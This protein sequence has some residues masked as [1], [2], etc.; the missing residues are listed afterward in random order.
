MAMNFPSSPID[1][2]Q[3]GGYVYDTAKGVWSHFDYLSGVSLLGTIYGWPLEDV[4]SWALEAN[5]QAVSRTTYSGLFALYGTTFGVGDG[6]TTFN[7]PNYKGRTLVGQDTAQTEF[8]VLG[9][10]G[11]AK[12]HTL[13]AQELPDHAHNSPGAGSA[14]SSGTSDIKARGIAP[15]DTSFR[16]GSSVYSTGTYGS[17]AITGDRSHNN[18]QPYTVVKWIICATTS[19]GDFN[20]EVQSA[21]VAQVDALDLRTA[22]GTRYTAAGT[23]TTGYVTY[24]TTTITASAR[25]VVVNLSATYANGNSG[26]NRTADF[27]VQMDGVTVGEELTGLYSP[28]VASLSTPINVA[29]TFVVT[30]TAGSRTF[31][32]QAK[33]SVGS[34]VT[35]NRASLAV[36][37]M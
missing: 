24:V 6:S 36:S 2:Q 10:T 18:L 31:T 17:T 13:T 16:T 1:G 8:D 12:T 32:L 4:P 22:A 25:P 34:A 27:R 7:L 37:E 11:G 19:T 9:E 30:P 35:L 28:Y 26:A 14:A 21:L 33:A 23:L 3:F 20:T 15:G 29:D 5:G